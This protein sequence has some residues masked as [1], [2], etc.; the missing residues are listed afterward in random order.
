MHHFDVV[1]C[2]Y[3]RKVAAVRAEKK[4]LICCHGDRDRFP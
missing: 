2:V 4:I 3:A 1:L